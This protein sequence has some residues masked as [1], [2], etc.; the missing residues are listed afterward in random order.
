MA[1]EP[2][3][4]RIR[5]KLEHKPMQDPL[6]FRDGFIFHADSDPSVVNSFD[7]LEYPL[8]FRFGLKCAP[9]R[10]KAMHSHGYVGSKIHQ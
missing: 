6:K 2:V 3:W 4:S 9:M 1:P 8:P 10:R 5:F 7:R